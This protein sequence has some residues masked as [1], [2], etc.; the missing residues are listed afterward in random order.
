M[1]YDNFTSGNLEAARQNQRT[2]NLYI[3]ENY[4]KSIAYWKASMTAIGFDM[5]YTVYPC[6]MPDESQ[7]KDI[8]TR[9]EKI[10]LPTV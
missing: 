3:N 2:L 8:K 4:G 1:F 7:L 10:G 6:L 9:L 5:G